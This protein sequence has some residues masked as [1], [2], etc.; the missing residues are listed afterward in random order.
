MAAHDQFDEID[1]HTRGEVL[2]QEVAQLIWDDAPGVEQ[3]RDPR[4]PAFAN[5]LIDGLAMALAESPGTIKKLMHGAAE[6]AKGLNVAQFQG[7]IE[8]IQNADD[9]RATE[10]RFALRDKNRSQQLLIVHNGSPVTCHHV[11]GM[12]LPF[13]TTKTN[14]ADQRGRFGIGLKTLRRIAEMIII[15]SLPYHFSGDQASLR[16][17][18]EEAPL[19]N[20]YDPVTDTLIVLDLTASFNEADLRAWFDEWDDDG[21]IFLFSVRRFRWCTIGGETISEKKL[22]FSDWEESGFTQ[23]H[24]AILGIRRRRIKAS[25][26]AWTVWKARLSVPSHLHPAHKTKSETTEIS[27]AVPDQPTHNS[28]YIG[29]KTRVPVSLTFSLDAQF[30]PSTAREELIENNWNNWLIERC[31]DVLADITKGL[32]IS[33]PR[34]A[35]KLVPLR[36][37]NVGNKA[38]NWLHTKFSIASSLARDEIGANASISMS[39]EIVPLRNLSYEIKT[40]SGLLGAPEVE[41]LFPQKR[42]VPMSVRDDSGRWR[43]VLD[44]LGVATTVGTGEL[45]VG[46]AR[47]L[48]DC[49]TPT[50]WVEAASILVTVS[51]HSKE[52]DLFGVP[53]LLSDK[54]HPL[55]CLRK[56]ETA[57]PLVIEY[58]NS[59]FS[60]RWKLLDR[61]HPAY[62][63][64][65]DG[66]QV[67]TWLDKNAA[68]KIS[69]DTGTELGAFAE[70]FQTEPVAID[71]EGLREIRDR[72]DELSERDAEDLG[73][74]VGAA[75]LL[76]GY[77]YKGGKSQKLKVSPMNAYLCKTLDC[78][79]L[80]WPIAAGS[81]PGI[82]WIAARYDVQ[83][84]TEVPGRKRRRA[85]GTISRGPRKFL[86]L[87]GAENA[88]R[89]VRTGT[90]K[91]GGQTR[92]KE[93]IAVNAEQVL[94]DFT[95]PDM[96]RVL[97][98]LARISMK[99][100]KVR[101]PALL[102]TLS[103]NW[104][105]LY[106]NK[107]T[108]PSQHVAR[109]Y[110]Y[111]KAPVNASWLIMLKEMKWIAIGQRE[112]VSPSAAVIKSA[113]TQTLYSTNAFALGI[114]PIDIGP[115][116][117]ATLKLITE[118]RVSD[119]VSLLREIRDGNEA[120]D[121]DRVKH[122]YRNIAK[123]CPKTASW[124]ARI[125][126][127]T[128]QDLR[129][130]F[131]EGVGLI[132]VG[133][134]LWRCPTDLL[135]GKDIFQDRHR[136]VPSSPTS[137]NLWLILDVKEP[138]LDDCLSFCKSL[139]RRAYDGHAT[140]T[141][142]D[143]YRY[144]EHLLSSVERKNKERLKTLPIPCFGK[145]ESKRPIYFVENNELRIELSKILPNYRFW[146]PPCDTRDLPNLVAMIN[147][148]KLN[149]NLKVVDNRALALVQGENLRAR[150]CQAVDFLS[151]ELARNDAMTR[152]KISLGWDQLKSIPLYVYDCP[153][154]VQVQAEDKLLWQEPVMVKLKALL[155][156][157]PLELHFWEDALPLRDYGGHAI[158]SLFP[159]ESRRR[160]DA[161]WVV[162]W[163]ESKGIVSEGIRLA[164]DEALAEAL[165][166]QTSKINAAPKGKIQ[167]TPPASQAPGLKPRTLKSSVGVIA[168]ATINP[169]NPP[170]P[171]IPGSGRILKGTSPEPSQPNAMGVSSVPIA[172]TTVDL[173][174]RGWEILVHAL[175]TSQ[176]EQLVDFRKR[177]GVGADGA[178]DWRTF[179][180]MKASGRGPQSSVEM[181]NAE[182]ERAKERGIHF[183]LALISGLETGEK[184]EVRLIRDPANRASVRPIN[185]IRLVRLTEAPAIVIQFDEDSP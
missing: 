19:P 131:C 3:I 43:D 119:L 149:P 134:G 50:W 71:D 21:L 176:D 95:S 94:Y 61:L 157:N 26:Q 49:K 97:K 34:E 138:S 8:V 96:E 112:R 90:I 101:S 86:M 130:K 35:W 66:E 123:H 27:V 110:T 154:A 84:K 30:D 25:E 83:L 59:G 106:S 126:D 18:D 75:L 153:V 155:A 137:A 124:N 179:V 36:N 159:V 48:F 143:V 78:D 54:N 182:Y 55:K 172:Y 47:S 161:E 73:P 170:K 5:A 9:V 102:R 24:K 103:R 166:E 70:R 175:N 32:L 45:L 185:G 67:V 42:A 144:M 92:T 56:T 150:F 115:D 105:R 169:G 85:D 109:L 81:L 44:E 114:E 165:K 181:S 180:E 171:A 88:P 160:I 139:A 132:Y 145:W 87:L 121:Y 100:A 6:A 58:G 77:V 33:N 39:Q 11:L 178:I 29:F 82:E 111:S 135:R 40:L 163:Q 31:A 1:S 129:A 125:G 146:T 46:F 17:V 13:L 140:A 93:L 108:V 41:R 23:L 99:D 57:R 147:V 184:C 60:E 7:L 136:F 53:F 65:T 76:D 63:M 183:M 117:A 104:E 162:A 173:E 174:Q 107:K 177:H 152:E 164:S 4:T 64:S 52:D 118:V 28:L 156:D 2:G 62:S 113:E 80:N 98:A 14:R 168:G 72:F 16:R 79:N 127:L 141:L 128:A 37:E 69:V 151:D 148:I 51:N 68:F 133:D 158:A 116:I 12:A 38:D 22:D 167:V 122:I 15:H 91:W 120:V 89:I 20:F 142:I 10:V 74:Q